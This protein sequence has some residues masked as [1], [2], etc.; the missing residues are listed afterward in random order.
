MSWLCVYPKFKAFN[1]NGNFLSGGKL[2]TYVAGGVAN[3]TTY[4][5]LAMTTP[6]A[7]PVVLD[8]LG[9]AVIYFNGAYKLTLKDA[10]D[11]LQWSMDNVRFMEGGTTFYSVADLEDMIASIGANDATVVCSGENTLTDDL[12]IGDNIAVECERPAMITVPAGKTL[13]IN[14]NFTAG[15]FQVFDG[16]G[17][18][19]FSGNQEKIFA[20]WFPGSDI[21]AKINAA[22]AAVSATSTVKIIVTAEEW[23]GATYS[24][25]IVVNK[26]VEVVFPGIRNTGATYTGIT[27]GIKLTGHGAVVSGGISLVLTGNVN[28][29]CDGF[30]IY[31]VS[32]CYVRDGMT[33]VNA[34]R[35]CFSIDAAATGAYQNVINGTV[36]LTGANTGGSLCWIGTSGAA[37]P[38]SNQIEHIIA[39]NIPNS[40]YGLH[41]EYGYANHI[42]HYYSNGGLSVGDGGDGS[43]WGVYYEGPAASYN[44][45]GTCGLEGTG[46]GLKVNAGNLFMSQHKN[47]VT[48]TSETIT[49]TTAAVAYNYLANSYLENCVARYFLAQNIGTANPDVA[50]PVIYGSTSGGIAP[51]D[52]TGNLI[53]A[54]RTNS[55]GPKDIVF[56][57]GYPSDI[58]MRITRSGTITG[59]R[60]T[61]GPV[62]TYS[63]QAGEYT[64]TVPNASITANS[65]VFIMPT[66]A[67]AAAA[68]GE[69][70][71]VQHSANNAGVSF[72]LTHNN[73]T[74]VGATFNY[75]ILN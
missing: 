25:P 44:Y 71:G 38:N 15:P 53:I 30:V 49:R 23:C 33:I 70:A 57:A 2:Y 48:G 67:A 60:T 61:H 62:G 58:A 73:T 51:F 41:I 75:F 50:Q 9:E 55:T 17:T 16:T 11:N 36:R 63:I 74:G 66:S 29:T 45:I 72:T 47:T 52:E 8:S 35:R 19:S 56:M 26:P 64:T 18:I 21:G 39:S 12:T 59:L 28:A 69:A 3:K 32:D 10:S 27:A 14:G 37:S 6:N 13:T 68:V 43:A 5:D 4:S 20:A 22:V 1:S 65:K 40:G 34:P 42:N 7:N 24:T 46:N 31:G 54:P